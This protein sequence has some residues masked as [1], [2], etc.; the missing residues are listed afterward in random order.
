[1]RERRT[2]SSTT[3]RLP[4]VYSYRRRTRLSGPKDAQKGAGNPPL[5]RR[6]LPRTPSA[7]SSEK[8]FASSTQAGFSNTW[9][10]TGQAVAPLVGGKERCR[11]RPTTSPK[12]RRCGTSGVCRSGWRSPLL[13][14]AA[15]SVRIF[16]PP[17]VR[18]PQTILRAFRSVEPR[19]P[20][21]SSYPS[22]SCT[23]LRVK[24]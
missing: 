3:G 22:S 8:A 7:R 16:M 13:T 20:L 10:N 9:Y 15:S 14:G 2:R 4:E 6:D 1:M 19:P 18:I 11:G 23:A 21:A 24:K 17:G 12:P 5:R